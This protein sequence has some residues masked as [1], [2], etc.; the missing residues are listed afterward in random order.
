MPINIKDALPARKILEAENIFVLKESKALSQ[1]IRPM[2]IAI[3]NLMPL[4]IE[5]ETHL[6]RLLSN[7]PLQVEID[8]I[9]T[10][11]YVCK[12]TS[13]SHLKSFYTTFD[14]IKHKKYDGMIITGAPVELIEFEQVE[15]WDEITKIFNWAENNV[16]STLHICW[17]AMAGLYYHYGVEK[18]SYNEKL[19]GVFD[20]IVVDRTPPIM[21]GFDDMFKA[22]H[23]RYSGI[24]KEDIESINHLEILSESKDAGIYIV[25]AIDKSRIFVTGHSEYDPCTLKYEFERD[26]S[27][28]LNIKTPKNYFENDDPANKPIVNWRSHANLL[29]SN[30]LNYYVYQETPYDIHKIKSNKL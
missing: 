19:F 3:L 20:H 25:A 24:R 1:D 8:L 30:W 2:Q 13:E 9:T 28:G 23:S 22:P 21:R 12:N 17:A 11:S 5:T 26:I 15:Y 4:K 7:S 16:T 27:K 10:D 29:F 14:K 18:H 6:L